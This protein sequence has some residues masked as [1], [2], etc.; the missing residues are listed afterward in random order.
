MKRIICVLL[1]VI[2]I[3]SMSACET[4]GGSEKQFVTIATGGSSGAYFALGGTVS[5]LLN[6]NLEYVNASVQS[7]GASAIN[8]TLIG[9]GKAEVAFVMN[10]VINYAYTGTE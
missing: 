8:A 6:E 3:M 4:D 1:S 5:N 9:E 2:M 10:D 7:T